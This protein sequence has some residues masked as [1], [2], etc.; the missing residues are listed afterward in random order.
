MGLFAAMGTL[1]ALAGIYGVTA[2]LVALRS[3]EF[4]IYMALGADGRRLVWLVLKRGFR[5][6]A[7]GLAAGIGGALVATRFLR[8]LLYGVAAIDP[9]TFGAAAALVAV[10][11]L[12][13]SLAP[14]RR[15]A[16]IDPAAALRTE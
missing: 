10:M 15:A 12:A 5:L 9:A 4:G 6:T 7:L 2:Y 11:A 1:L 13:A 16:R 8:G 14:A 3:R